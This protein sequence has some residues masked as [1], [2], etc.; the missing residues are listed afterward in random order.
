MLQ[1]TS[2]PSQ[3]R[4]EGIMNSLR[5]TSK[6]RAG[7]DNN[8]DIEKENAGPQSVFLGNGNNRD[9]NAFEERESLITRPILGNG[10]TGVASRKNTIHVDQET[11][12]HREPNPRRQTEGGNPSCNSQGISNAASLVNIPDQ[13][14]NRTSGVDEKRQPVIW[15]TSLPEWTDEQL[16]MLMEFD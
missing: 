15:R 3:Q 9:Q 7:A 1:R 5:K 8:R 13:E 6:L 12:M 2:H 4:T 10:I 16:D 11:V 14:S